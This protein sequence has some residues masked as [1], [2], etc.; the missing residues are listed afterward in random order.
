MAPSPERDKGSCEPLGAERYCVRFAI[1]AGV[2]EELQELRALLRAP[3]PDPEKLPSF[4]G[5][6]NT[7]SLLVRLA[8]A[9][10]TKS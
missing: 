4:Q 8:T 9:R 5:L 7:T 10:Q 1:D 2:H 6:N 3:R